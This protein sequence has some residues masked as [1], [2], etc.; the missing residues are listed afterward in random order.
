MP[1]QLSDHTRLD[2]FSSESNEFVGRYSLY[3][4]SLHSTGKT[5]GLYR[6][7]TAIA[8]SSTKNPNT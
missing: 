1:I 6:K 5:L 8:T 2:L 7:D 3:T 4:Y